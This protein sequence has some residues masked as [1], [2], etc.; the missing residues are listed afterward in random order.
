MR[1]N[2]RDRVD[3]RSLE[4]RLIAVS[5]IEFVRGREWRRHLGVDIAA[6]DDVE[7]WTFGETGHDL[8]APPAEPD[9]ADPDHSLESRWVCS[10]PVNFAACAR[11][12]SSMFTTSLR[13]CRAM[14]APFG[15]LP[16]GWRF[17]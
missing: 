12:N 3:V 11:G 16:Y 4:Q 14:P 9:N 7:T 15:M 10:P 5:E 8:L 1:C 6:S 2:H 17:C 13:N